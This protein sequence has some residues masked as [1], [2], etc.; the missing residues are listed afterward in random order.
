MGDGKLEM[1]MAK[2]YCCAACGRELTPGKYDID[3]SPLAFLGMLKGQ[4][5]ARKP[6]YISET[7]LESLIECGKRNEGIVEMSMEALLDYA[8]SEENQ[9]WLEDSKTNAEDALKVFKEILETR[10]KAKDKAKGGDEDEENSF[11]LDF[12]KKRKAIDDSDDE[13]NRC[14]PGFTKNMTA[15]VINNFPEGVARFKLESHEEYGIRF[16]HLSYTGLAKNGAGTGRRCPYCK[17]KILPDAFKKTQ[18]LVG[19]VG[20]QKVGKS[21][22]ISALCNT[23]LNTGKA[24]TLEMPQ[25][26]WKVEYAAEI[27][28]YRKG[29]VLSKTA[30]SGVNT[31]NPSVVEENAI[32]TFVDVPGEAIQDPQTGDFNIDAVLNRFK[33]ILCCD[34]YIFCAS[35]EMVAQESEQGQMI[36]VF[37]SLLSNLENQGRPILFALTQEDEKIRDNGIGTK[38]A[39]SGTLKNCLHAK[40]LYYKETKFLLDKHRKLRGILETLAKDCYLTAITCSAYGFE[41]S[42]EEDY[43]KYLMNPENNP[44]RS[45]EPK[46]ISNIIDWVEKLYGVREVR[47]KG[48]IEEA[49][50]LDGHALQRSEVHNTKEVCDYISWMFV[51]PSDL[52]KMYSEAFDDGFPGIVKLILLN[53][54]QKLMKLKAKLMKQLKQQKR[55]Q[56]QDG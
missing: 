16:S 35:Y 9:Q 50:K 11:A 23:L 56:N 29:Y 44:S 20:F 1:N 36:S 2:R 54:K 8:Y 25:E 17:A 32:W 14:I 30:S 6:I 21:C 46:N 12:L 41:P 52:D 26:T 18:Y 22:L 45:P 10:R 4:S 27:E 28:R 42:S 15:Q 13:I 49:V 5:H 37:K 38:L 48:K 3:L 51:N 19:V 43:Q 40:Y 55:Q 24:A 39:D 31:Y 53:S 34:A 47:P 33:S 7:Q